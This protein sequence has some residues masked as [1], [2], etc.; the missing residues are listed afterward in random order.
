MIILFNVPEIISPKMKYGIK[1]RSYK[2]F[3]VVYHE[4][5]EAEKGHYLTDAYHV[6]CGGWLRYDDSIVSS[7]TEQQ[8]GFY[9]TL[10]CSNWLE[11]VFVYFYTLYNFQVLHP[12]SPRTPY[13]L[14]YRR[15][16]TMQLPRHPQP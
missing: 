12:R 2:L 11:F 8:V 3:A 15:Q 10:N 16:D 14:L 7:V 5:S 9:T 6:G 4:G 13:L 1:Q